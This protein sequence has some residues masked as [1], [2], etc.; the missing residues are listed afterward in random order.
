M[1]GEILEC[2]FGGMKVGFKAFF[3][4]LPIYNQLS[5]IPQDII[6]MA[7]GIPS[8]LITVIVV[9]IKIYKRFAH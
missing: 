6:C 3:S 7:L 9:V 1:L 5:S 8:A 4:A 2:I